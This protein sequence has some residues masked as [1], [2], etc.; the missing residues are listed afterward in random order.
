MGVRFPGAVCC[1]AKASS[2]R[3]T[4]SFASQGCSS[5][6]QCNPKAAFITQ[7]AHH[8]LALIFCDVVMEIV[9]HNITADC[10]AKHRDHIFRVTQKTAL[11]S[12]NLLRRFL[13][14]IIQR[15]SA[16]IIQK[17]LH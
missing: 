8:Q 16:Q 4:R 14:K 6:V 11:G 12:N 1:C 17:Q 9:R 10:G 2:K 3:L 15:S 7:R 5:G 13:S